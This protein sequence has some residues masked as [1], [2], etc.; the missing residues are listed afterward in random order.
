MKS[1]I[2]NSDSVKR[3]YLR[4]IVNIESSLILVN[5]NVVT[6]YYNEVTNATYDDT[7]DDYTFVCNVF[8]SDI[9]FFINDYNVVVA[10]KLLNLD[11]TNIIEIF[12][13]DEL[14]SSDAFDKNIFEDFLLKSQFVVFDI[15]DSRIEFASQ[16]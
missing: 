2:I 1:Y 4:E 8:L 5:D 10:K 7:Q 3:Y 6:I 11:S 14:Q 16:T 12:C 9:T 15:I 13:F